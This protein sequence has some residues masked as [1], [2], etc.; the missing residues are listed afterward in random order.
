M[1]GFYPGHGVIAH[2]SSGLWDENIPSCE[3]MRGCSQS[4]LAQFVLQECLSRL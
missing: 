3:V 1:M 2:G 4:V